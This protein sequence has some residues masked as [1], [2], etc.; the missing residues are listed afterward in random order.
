[1]NTLTNT[2]SS[3]IIAIGGLGGSGTRVVAQ[4]FIDSGIYMGDDLNPSNDNQFFTR[5]LKNPIW[6]EQATQYDINKRLR[7]LKK[8]MTGSNLNLFE[9]IEVLQACSSNPTIHSDKNYYKWFLKRQFKGKEKELRIWG[10]KEPNTHLLLLPLF[11]FFPEMKY[12]HVVRHGLDMAFSGNKNQLNYWGKKF[13]ISV[14]KDDDENVLSKKQLDYWIKTTQLAIEI[15]KKFG[16]R[17]YLLNYQSL[18][19]QPITEVPKLIDFWGNDT[20]PTLMK[21]LISIPKIS[22]SNGRYKTKDLSIFSGEQI[23]AVANLGFQIT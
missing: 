5:L 8:Y 9:I 7:I 10:W 6:L 20:N 2:R 11:N 17:F 14:E 21:K 13:G 18:C 22:S 19:E 23:Q 15:G 16:D 3:K 1:M 4:I 12:V